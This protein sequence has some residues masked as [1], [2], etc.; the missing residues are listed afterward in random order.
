VYECEALQA[1][2]YDMVSI[3]I[4][5][6]SFYYREFMIGRF[7]VNFI[8]VSLYKERSITIDYC[9]FMIVASKV[10]DYARR[11]SN[12]SVHVILGEFD[13]SPTTIGMQYF[14]HCAQTVYVYV[15]K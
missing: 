14:Q 5:C 8:P 9:L 10:I 11:K 4:L 7:A 2:E 6:L 12:A 1:V 15:R 3:S 13:S